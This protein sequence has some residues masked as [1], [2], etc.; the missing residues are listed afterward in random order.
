MIDHRG[1]SPAPAHRATTPGSVVALVDAGSGVEREL[2]GAWLNDGGIAKE[3]GVDA[4]VTQ[5]D[6]D[7]DAIATRSAGTTTRWSS[8]CVCC[9]CH[10]NAT[11]SGESP[12]PTWHC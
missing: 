2:V 3:F 6:L 11:G 4:P 7:A 8:Q 1:D 5:L 9:G 12:S 10:P